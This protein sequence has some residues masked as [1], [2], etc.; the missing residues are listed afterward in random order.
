MQP[1]VSKYQEAYNRTANRDFSGTNCVLC[2]KSFEDGSAARATWAGV[3]I[4]TDV[5][6]F[7][8]CA[9]SPCITRM[10]ARK[11]DVP[12]EDGSLSG[13]SE[14]SYPAFTRFEDFGALVEAYRSSDKFEQIERLNAILRS[15]GKDASAVQKMPTERS[16]AW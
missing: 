6:W 7:R 9:C 3:R 15:P 11:L 12:E 14:S 13:T 4:L 1:G 5:G 8:G 2:Q 16:R 10:V